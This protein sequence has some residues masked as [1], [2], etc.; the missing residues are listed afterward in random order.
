MIEPLRPCRVGPLACWLLLTAPAFGGEDRDRLLTMAQDGN[1]AAIQSITSM[2]CRFERQPWANTTF[3]QA[4]KEFSL[5]PGRFWRSGSTYR[6]FKPMG[7]G[8]TADYVVR[9]GVGL[10]L[11]KGGP[12]P[13]PMLTSEP[14]RPVDGV[15]GE[16]WEYLLFSHWG[17][18]APSFYPFSDLLQHPHVI[19][20]AERLPAP[21]SDIHIE[22]SHSGGR[23]EFWFDPKVNYLIRKSIMI[24]AAGM[25]RWENEVVEFTEPA[26]AVYVPT[27]IE[28]RCSVKG[29]LRAVVRTIV[30]E[31]KVNQP[32]AENALRLPGIAGM[33]CIDLTRDV[34]FRVDA[35]GRRNGPES[36]VKV[37]RV[38]PNTPA[39]LPTGPLSLSDPE[40]SRPPTPW[41]LWLLIASAL[42]LMVAVVLAVLRR[43]KQ[44][45]Q[46]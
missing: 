38:A 9:N 21:A 34:Q 13:R 42:L 25:Y 43:R 35:D 11:R 29:Q 32:L 7:D 17:W 24:P 12:L 18:N 10:F 20:S 36:R 22:L 46:A 16:M 31:L 3:E 45:L 8:T 37:T 28:H 6:L 15:G 26:P 27:T 4:G 41:W 23:L 39:P 1:R 5:S 40:P 44:A 30:S 33:N 19:H 2:E 14:P